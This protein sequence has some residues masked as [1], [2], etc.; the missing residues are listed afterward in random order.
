MSL[1]TRTTSATRLWRAFM[2]PTVRQPHAFCQHALRATWL[3]RPFTSSRVVGQQQQDKAAATTTT[4]TPK[5]SP[6]RGIPYH[7]LKIGIPKETMAL[8]K[9]VAAT[10]ESVQRL[11]PAGFQVL[12]EQGAGEGAFF[13][14]ASY[15]QAGARVVESVWNE[16]DI[17][18]K[19]STVRCTP[20]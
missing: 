14:N 18:L 5:K 20:E 19:V 7:Q 8:E 2:A 15:E 9:R 17:V 6:P 16:A 12:V 4:T 3:I 1:T 10:P 13:D 11:V